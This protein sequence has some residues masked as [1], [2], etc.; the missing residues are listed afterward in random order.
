[1]IKNHNTIP[2]FFLLFYLFFTAISSVAQPDGIKLSQA[3]IFS[4]SFERGVYKTE[5]SI[6]NKELTGLI[7]IKRT[8]ETYRVVFLSEIGIK[9]FDIEMGGTEQNDFIVHYMLEMLNRKQI[10][11]FI[12][13]TFRMLS[14]SFGEIKNEYSFLCDGSN[15]QVKVIKTQTNGKFRFDYH[16]NFGQVFMMIHYGFLKKKLSIELSDYDYLAPSSML[17][18]Q[19]KIRLS[20]KQIEQ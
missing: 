12:E 11:T 20:L 1:M 10:I 7:L 14:M 16:P 4:N 3:R 2:S 15:N 18:T 8:G 13:S 17:A 19:K 5:M 9:Y 6:H